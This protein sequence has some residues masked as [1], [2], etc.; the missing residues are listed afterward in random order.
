M[1]KTLV[2]AMLANRSGQV[3][4]QSFAGWKGR[5]KVELKNQPEATEGGGARARLLILFYIRED[6]INFYANVS[7]GA[8]LSG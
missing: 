4:F 3:W 7:R 6:S 8:R 1:S 5:E 2:Q